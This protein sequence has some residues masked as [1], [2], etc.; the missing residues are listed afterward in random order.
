MIPGRSLRDPTLNH[1]QNVTAGTLWSSC[2]STTTPFGSLC[3]SIG[4]LAAV[5]AA[6]DEAA[7]AA[8]FAFG[9]GAAWPDAGVRAIS[10]A[11]APARLVQRMKSSSGE[12]R[13]Q[14][15]S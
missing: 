6:V 1:C 3:R 8:G 12:S 4:K 13:L 5:S 15:G 2:V 7:G 10:S 9:F 14:Q 11:T